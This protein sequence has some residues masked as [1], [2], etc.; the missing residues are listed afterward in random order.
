V[1]R[2]R[3]FL[4]AGS[5]LGLA[6]VL[7]GCGIRQGREGD[8]TASPAS[9][10][11]PGNGAAL[12]AR[13]EARPAQP[14]PAP[15]VQPLGLRASRDSLLYLPGGLRPG[16]PSALVVTLHGAGGDA[17]GGLS[18]LRPL[19]ERHGLVLLAPASHGSTWDAIGGGYGL[20]VNTIDQALD[21]VFQVVPVDFERIGVAGFSDGASYALGL[22]LANGELFSRLIAFSPGFIPGAGRVGTPSV[23]VS[24]G[25]DDHVLPIGS[26]SR[27]IVP[28]LRR[29]GYDV[30]YHEF[31]GPHVVPPQ[32]AQL[33][34]DWLGWDQ[35]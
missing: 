17:E 11:R 24:H 26:T 27:R 15:G 2:R 25:V 20:D 5:R 8:V 3:G 19:A 16:Q 35:P 18:L 30:T 28:A 22:G 34:V 32:I 14:L 1:L 9:P 21:R 7:T 6:G 23:F 33:A 13:P 29:D 12:A 31:D 4:T 10:S